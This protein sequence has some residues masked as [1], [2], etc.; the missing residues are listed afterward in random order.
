MAPSCRSPR[1]WRG[2]RPCWRRS[3]RPNRR[4]IMARRRCARS[5]P[6]TISLS[7]GQP[8]R[9]GGRRGA[10]ATRPA[11]P[12]RWC[13]GGR[14]SSTGSTRGSAN[15][16]STPPSPIAAGT[17][18]GAYWSAQTALSAL[19]VVLAGER[20]AFALCRPPGH[21]CGADYLRRLLLPQQCRHRGAKR[22]ST[23]AG[24]GSRS[25]MSTIITATA[26]RTSSTRRGDV[27]FVSIHA[28]PVMDYPYFWGHA[29]ETGEGDG[30][31]TTLNL[32]LPRGTD[33]AA[34]LPRA[35]RGAGA[36]RGLC[37]GSADRLLR[38][39]HLRRRSDL[40]F[41]A[42]DGGLCRHRQAHRRLGL[43]NLIVMEGGY[44]VDALGAN[45]AAFLS[46]F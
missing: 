33:L 40:A 26:R 9:T 29:D 8:T 21:H 43:P 31:G 5:M 7:S 16:A 17:W 28:D 42:G 44:A 10:K 38:R 30:E 46:G 45:V 15:T 22:R 19:D 25:S 24:A 13:G 2:P 4:S 14:S 37:A 23:R 27:L 20:S 12:G 32:P 36:D 41:P 34:Y 1:R 39:R 3:G 11:M 18:E 6:R 35:R